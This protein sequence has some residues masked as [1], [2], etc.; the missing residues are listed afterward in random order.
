MKTFSFVVPTYNRY[1]LLHTLLYDIYQKCTPVL[2]VIIVDD[3]STEMSY[4]DG[5][6]WW[7]TNGML[8][9]RHV[10]MEKNVNFLKASNAGLQRAKGEIVCLI[11]ND[12]RIH[13]DIVSHIDVMVSSTGKDLL[14]GGR[15]LDWNTGW[16]TF[17]GVT[18]PYLEGWLLATTK[19]GWE[20]LGYFDE[21]YAPSDMEDVDISTQALSQGFILSS[22]AD[23]WTTH[24][25]AQSI[26]YGSAREAITIRNKEKFR[27]KWI[28]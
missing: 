20:R 17:D 9:I 5:L 22:L 8:P 7:K 1:D 11:S 4:R 23:S 24:I 15:Y 3:C 12:V 14:V 27:E 18:F 28:K 6:N 10:R 26:S 21:R 25:G 16:N 13:A 19:S 2:E